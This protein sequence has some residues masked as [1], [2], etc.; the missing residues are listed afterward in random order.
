MFLRPICGAFVLCYGAVATCPDTDGSPIGTVQVLN[1][2]NLGPQNNGTAAALVHGQLNHQHASSTCATIG[3]ALLPFS[4]L[5]KDRVTEL[6]HQLDYLVATGGLKSNDSI[7]VQGSPCEAQCLAYSYHL[8][9]TSAVSCGWKLPALCTSTVAAA[10]DK[11]GTS[12]VESSAKV[13]IA[14][15][16]YKFTGYRD[17]RSFRF[18][19]IPFANPPV[20]KLRFMAPQNYTGSKAIDATKM[21]ASCMQAESPYGDTG[22]M[23]EDCLYL[24]VFTP[25]I[26]AK[27]SH[28][29]ARRPVAVYFYG[30]AF[31]VG[32]NSMIDYDGGNFASRND[33]VIVTV[34]YRLG[35]LGFL[36]T[37]SLVDGSLSIKDQIQA[38]RWVRDR[39]AAFGGDPDQ[40]TIFGQSAGGQ[41]T[42]ALMSSSSAKGLF[43]RAIVQSAPV[44]FPWYPREVYSKIVT[45]A[46]AGVV[47]CN[48][49][50]TEMDLVSCLQAVPASSYV[51]SS[52]A[53]LKNG[54]SEIASAVSHKFLHTSQIV[55]A[56]E[57][58]MP[59]VDDQ[60]TGVIDDQFDTLL[61]NG[62]LPSRVPVMFTTVT[63][64]ATLFVN[65]EFTEPAGSSQSSMNAV[66]AVVFPSA[67]SEKMIASG[68]FATDT[69]DP[70]SV[71]NT[72]GKAL[73]ESEW[74]CAQAYLLDNG[75]T[76]IFPSLY[77]VE[78]KN[79]HHQ[80]TIDVPRG[81]KSVGIINHDFGDHLERRWATG[82]CSKR[83]CFWCEYVQN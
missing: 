31:M 1:Y 26:P 73:T 5:P 82:L 45:P 57:P 30:G 54:L 39:I 41:S 70:D 56:I 50:K 60:G 53:A 51:N 40:V 36:A 67:L 83:A 2:N 32:A 20:K 77:E 49:T 19:G 75:G 71:R 9:K 18:L 46:I 21:P 48:G 35:A 66:L 14:S 65:Q 12:R 10:T 55:A 62:S 22:N 7:W 16:G 17:K 38:L 25:I 79:G 43:H 52:A 37:D 15:E 28:S 24:N 13:T 61:R 8:K 69:I 72:I 34:N 29:S 81:R 33:V 59:M 78:I 64:E 47:G 42:V 23:S 3:E 74:S 80:T 27:V 58:L 63:D 44:D 68:A 11:D 76:S 6:Q 4:Q